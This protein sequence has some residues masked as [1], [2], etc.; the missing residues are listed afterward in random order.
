MSY[1]TL[2]RPGIAL[3]LLATNGM[4]IFQT[5]ETVKL[6]IKNSFLKTSLLILK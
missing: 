1:I 6:G 3:C 4:N 2:G 5:D